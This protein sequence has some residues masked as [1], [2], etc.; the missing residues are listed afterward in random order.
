[1]KL[2]RLVLSTAFLILSSISL[3]AQKNFFKD[4]E[5]YYEGGMLTRAID[6]Y[7]KAYT[8]ALP[9]GGGGAKATKL[10]TKGY[11][12]YRLGDCYYRFREV[13]KAQE[14]YEKAILLKYDKE[15]PDVYL[16]LG[17]VLKEQ[18][19]YD[20]AKINYE[21]FYDITG[22]ARG[23][24]GIES[25]KMS[26]NLMKE[27]TRYRVVEETVLN[28]EDYDFSPLFVSSKFDELM[29]TSD[30]KGATGEIINDRTG[31]QNKDVWFTQRDNKGHWSQPVILDESINTEHD[32]GA[33]V[34]Y[35]NG[36]ELYFTRCIHDKKKSLGCDLYYAEKKG[37]RWSDA[38]KLMLRPEGYEDSAIAIGHPAI[39][40]DGKT[41]LF[42]SDMPGGQGGL[43]IW[44]SEYDRREKKWGKPVNLGPSINTKGNEMFPHI[45]QN[46]DLY[47]ASDGHA[48]L[49]GLDNFKCKKSGK[50]QWEKP[51]NLGVPLNSNA[52]DYGIIFEGNKE[53]GLFTSNRKGKTRDDIWSFNLPPKI[54]K[55]TC[56]VMD[57]DTKEPIPDAE[58]KL[59]GSDN[60]LFT[61]TTDENGMVVYDKKPNG[62]FYVTEETNYNIEVGK[63]GEYLNGAQSFTTVGVE[64][65]KEFVYEF[66]L[67][68]IIQP[69]RLP[70]VR[71]DYDSDV[72]QVNDSVHSKDSLN[73]LYDLMIDN[74]TIIV[75][76]R[77]HTDCRGSDKYNRD[78]ALRRAKS[79]VNYLVEEK[80]IPKD[81]LIPMGMGEDEPLPGLECKA[82]DKLPTKQEQEAAHQRNRRTDCKVESWDYVPKEDGN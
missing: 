53:R 31:G 1:M 40:N 41:L 57:K 34:T 12:Q 48:G 7:M 32:E 2:N 65:S 44:M 66:L 64:E 24:E 59:V 3:N 23:K 58:I 76:L 79:C 47:I 38:E 46:G 36:R 15:M 8:K 52:D 80:G 14:A 51:V 67:T 63:Q 27:K 33:A 19:S 6:S 77:S 78:L 18:S 54:F 17:D 29:F 81:R 16:K 37:K 70:E 11:I 50:L 4:A 39:S 26:L 61:L 45:R 43:D 35:K 69:I 55:L 56:V 13:E 21:K 82:I 5:M 28:T 22:D 10:G 75:R 60:N 73:F 68:N 72:L 30:R 42:A 62:Q 9:Q 49:G 74:P 71:Y 25:C 20:E